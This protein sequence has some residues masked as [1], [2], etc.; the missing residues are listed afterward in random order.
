M[1]QHLNVLLVV[2]GPKLDT[3]LE[4]WPHQCWVQGHYYLPIPAGHTVPDRARMPLAFL[5]TWAH[6]WLM[7]SRLSTK[8]PKILFCWAA[9]QPLLPKPV[10]W[11]GVVVTTVQDPALGLV[12]THTVGLGPSIRSVQILLQTLHRITE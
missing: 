9:F 5:A 11:H 4:V 7:F 2:R 12:E 1:L 10:A 8:H 6:C 3:V